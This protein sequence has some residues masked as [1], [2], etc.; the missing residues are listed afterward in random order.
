ML[1]VS[2]F[3][4]AGLVYNRKMAGWRSYEQ[5]VDAFSFFKKVSAFHPG[6]GNYLRGQAS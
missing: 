4:I 2:L 6:E 5:I 3:A 1:P